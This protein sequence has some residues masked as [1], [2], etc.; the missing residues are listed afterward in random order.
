MRERN[1]VERREDGKHPAEVEGHGEVV[2]YRVF[3]VPGVR[4]EGEEQEKDPQARVQRFGFPKCT[5][6]I[7]LNG[8]LLQKQQKS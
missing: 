4:K 2:R 5:S 3:A 6:H 7:S 8:R 1:G